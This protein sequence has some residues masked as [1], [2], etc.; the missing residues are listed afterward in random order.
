MVCDLEGHLCQYN[1]KHFGRDGR[2]TLRR[3]ARLH[4]GSLPALTSV[5]EMNRISPVEEGL[6]V[7]PP[8]TPF[9]STR[10]IEG[11][12]DEKEEADGG[13][14]LAPLTRSEA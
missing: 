1:D 14:H 2:S 6:E 12:M 9:T 10:L 3:S 13:D 11:E 5:A 4:T 7:V 8:M